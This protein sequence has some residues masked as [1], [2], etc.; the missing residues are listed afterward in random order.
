[1]KNRN[2]QR[3]RLPARLFGELLPVPHPQDVSY[4]VANA[5]SFFSGATAVAVTGCR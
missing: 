1:M 2:R 3:R 4:P 5:D